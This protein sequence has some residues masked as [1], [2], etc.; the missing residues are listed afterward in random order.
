MAT[1]K[2]VRSA[3][4]KKKLEFEIVAP[5][6]FNSVTLGRT[7]GKD[8]KSVLGRTVLVSMRDLTGKPQ[9]GGV[10]ARFY[11]VDVKGDRAHTILKEHEV[12][13]S[14]IKRQTRRKRSKVEVVHDFS[15]RD[16]M[17]VRMKTDVFTN[18]RASSAQ[19]TALR[20]VVVDHLSS[21]S[22][23]KGYADVMQEV[24]YGKAAMALNEAC[25]KLMPIRRVEIRK[26]ELQTVPKFGSSPEA[27]A[28]APAAEE[29]VVEAVAEEIER[30]E[31]EKPKK[32]RK[33]KA[34][35]EEA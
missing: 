6:Y 7:T 25:K 10:F 33:K 30:P 31:E 27:V 9:M 21:L 32:A 3:S 22:Q 11:V 19:Q 4:K 14:M 13:P 29:A 20:K 17:R 15:T 1:T 23:S 8:A 26:T 5:S 18:R 12:S 28:E 24:V 2:K 35:P 34:E 16:G